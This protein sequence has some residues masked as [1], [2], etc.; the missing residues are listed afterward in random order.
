MDLVYRSWLFWFRSLTTRRCCNW[1]LYPFVGRCYVSCVSIARQRFSIR[2][3]NTV[4]LSCLLQSPLMPELSDSLWLGPTRAD[5]VQACSLRRVTDVTVSS[6]DKVPFPTQD[7]HEP[8][9]SPVS[10]HS[11]AYALGK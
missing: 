5:K 11:R 8:S 2:I 9:Y 1:L 10:I 6:R 3:L 7:I 4:I